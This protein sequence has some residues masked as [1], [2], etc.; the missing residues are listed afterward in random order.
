MEPPGTVTSRQNCDTPAQEPEP[1]IQQPSSP[2]VSKAHVPSQSPHIRPMQYVPATVYVCENVP[3]EETR[4]Q[5]LPAIPKKS[6]A[7][8]TIHT[9]DPHSSHPAGFT[10]SHWTCTVT[11]MS[12][13]FT[14]DTLTFSYGSASTTEPYIKKSI[15]TT[16]LLAIT[17]F[18]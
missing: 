3:V 4:V 13:T 16:A 9:S 7:S 15:S 17:P 8:H 18:P 11:V 5:L 1:S 2:S 12:E 10:G 14:R 6:A